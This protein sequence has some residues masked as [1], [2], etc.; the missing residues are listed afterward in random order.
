MDFLT[1]ARLRPAKGAPSVRG[2]QLRERGNIGWPGVGS[3]VLQ[4]RVLLYGLKADPVRATNAGDR[5]RDD[6]VWKA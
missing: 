1:L 6:I 5:S 4:A 2:R 3:P